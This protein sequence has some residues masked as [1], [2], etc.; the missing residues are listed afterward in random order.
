MEELK[1][2]RHAVSGTQT[3][4][5]FI[6]Q[7][8]PPKERGACRQLGTITYTGGSKAEGEATI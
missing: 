6:E 5:L 1:V 4:G 3:A 7:A 2:L 8:P